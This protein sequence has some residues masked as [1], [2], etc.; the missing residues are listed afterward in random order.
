MKNFVTKERWV[1]DY[2][3]PLELNQGDTVEIVRKYVN[4]PNWKGWFF[5]NTNNN[6]GYIPE[7]IIDR[8]GDKKGLIK[9]NY[10][11]KELNIKKGE[12]VIGLKELNGWVWVKRDSNREE[13]WLPLDILNEISAPQN[14]L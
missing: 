14:N 6:S 5:C 11:A 12:K 9:E 1:S 2:L 4:N 7:Q 8:T 3:N 10:S 13:G